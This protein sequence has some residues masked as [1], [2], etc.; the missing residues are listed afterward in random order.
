MKIQLQQQSVRLRL[1]E[2]ELA[3]LLD[4]ETLHSTTQLGVID[5]WSMALRLHDGAQPVLAAAAEAVLINLPYEAVLT[6]AG[7]LPC[8]DGLAWEV[9]TSNATLQLQFDVDVRDSVRQRG[10][11]RRTDAVITPA[12]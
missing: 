10:P 12:V 3:Q 7:R 4:G 2:G 8:R 11:R 6:L 5:N 1:D 9:D